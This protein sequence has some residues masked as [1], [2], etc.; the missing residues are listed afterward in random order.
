[1]A[2]VFILVF[3]KNHKIHKTQNQL[4]LCFLK[5]A[6]FVSLEFSSAIGLRG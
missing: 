6:S 2:Q 1:M 5:T 3:G 4:R